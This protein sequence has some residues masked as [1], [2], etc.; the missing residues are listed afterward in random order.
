MGQQ[1]VRS[2]TLG[3]FR[4]LWVF[5]VSAGSSL[6]HSHLF[7]LNPIGNL[8]PERGGGGWRDRDGCCGLSPIAATREAT[9]WSPRAQWPG[10]S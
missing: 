1:W 9:A 5:Q 4:L 7:L 10:G 6:G 2:P 3:T 8:S